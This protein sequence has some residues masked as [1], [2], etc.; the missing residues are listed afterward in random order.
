MI[1][2]HHREV[3]VGG[4]ELAGLVDARGP[5]EDDARE[6]EALGP[7]SAFGE[8]AVDEKLVGPDPAGRASPHARQTTT[9]RNMPRK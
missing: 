9:S 5:G 2:A 4:K 1:L 7:C 3:G 6:D 8:A